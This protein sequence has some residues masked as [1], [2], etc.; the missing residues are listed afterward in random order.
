[1]QDSLYFSAGA[2]GFG[3]SPTVTIA[4]RGTKIGDATDVTVALLHDLGPIIDRQSKLSKQQGDYQQ[5]TARWNEQASEAT[6][7]IQR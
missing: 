7:E 5:R 3:G 6:T 4:E 2:A 1:L